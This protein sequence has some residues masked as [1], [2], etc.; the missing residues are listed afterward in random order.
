MLCRSRMADRFALALTFAE[1]LVALAIFSGCSGGAKRLE[2]QLGAPVGVW[3]SSCYSLGGGN[4]SILR[5]EIQNAVFLTTNTHFSSADCAATSQTTEVVY[6]TTIRKIG[7]VVETLEGAGKIDIEL[8]SVT[9]KPLSPDLVAK[10][11]STNECGVS[12]WKLNEATNLTGRKC[13]TG[14]LD[15][16]GTLYFDIYKADFKATPPTYQ[17]GNG[18]GTSEETRPAALA[19]E[20]LKLDR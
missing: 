20:I 13:G 2:G 11:N 19:E 14:T 15:P 10:Y 3:K 17:P 4:Y 1:A 18:L 8:V 16:K 5:I 9:E 7:E 6:N 12:N